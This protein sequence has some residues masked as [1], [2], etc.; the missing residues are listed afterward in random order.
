MNTK[1]IVT[2][3]SVAN[4]LL[5]VFV[6]FLI[7]QNHEYPKS[8]SFVK[9]T[10]NNTPSNSEASTKGFTPARA[11]KSYPHTNSEI[12]HEQPSLGSAQLPASMV[13]DSPDISIIT[14]EQ[15]FAWETLQDEFLHQVGNE[16]P[17][18]QAELEIWQEARLRNDEAFRLKFGNQ[19][20]LIQ[21]RQAAIQDANPE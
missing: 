15:V 2:A 3:I 16:L 18:N 8:K 17:S 20:F 10:I 11:E 9:N 19:A 13:Q 6:L 4:L 1:K 14:E 5:F 7:L 21:E 12:F